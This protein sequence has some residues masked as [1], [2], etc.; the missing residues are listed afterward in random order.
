LASIGA[1]AMPLVT[2]IGGTGS[3]APTACLVGSRGFAGGAA[4]D[5]VCDAACDGACATRGVAAGRPDAVAA[6]AAAEVRTAATAGVAAAVVAARAAVGAVVAGR[7]VDP[8][9]EVAA[10]FADRGGVGF[11]RSPTIWE[12]RRG[13]AAGRGTEFGAGFGTA[14]GVALGNDAGGLAAARGIADAPADVGVS[15][16]PMLD[17]AGRADGLI[18]GRDN[19]LGDGRAAALDPE[20][21]AGLV[22][23][24][25]GAL[26]TGLGDCAAGLSDTRAGAGRD[27]GAGRSLS[28]GGGLDPVTTECPL[29][30]AASSTTEGSPPNRKQCSQILPGLPSVGTVAKHLSGSQASEEQIWRNGAPLPIARCDGTRVRH[31]CRRIRTNSTARY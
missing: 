16:S 28:S 17:V 14:F 20:L 29:L 2:E 11:N 7:A 31:W 25:A 24:F 6:A 27:A 19:G 4:C 13:F 22:A 9:V 3:P 26:G 18:E 23:G 12:G 5:A 10:P 21:A 1:K 30:Q 15:R 8:V